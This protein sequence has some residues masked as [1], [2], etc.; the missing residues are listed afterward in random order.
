MGFSNLKEHVEYRHFLQ[1]GRI[2]FAVG[3]VHEIGRRHVVTTEGEELEADEIILCTG[4]KVSFPFL[5][6]DLSD[7]L[8][9]SNAEGKVHLNAYRLA[10]HPC[11][12]TLCALGYLLT[13]GNE[14]C[15]GEMQARWALAHWVGHHPLP[16]KEQIESDLARRKNRGK[17][18]QFVPY[19]SYMDTL[20]SAC[21]VVPDVS[22]KGFLANPW[23]S[24]KLWSSP[25]VPAQFRISGSHAWPK[26]V[27]FVKSQPFVA[28]R[29]AEL[30]WARPDSS[31]AKPA[32]HPALASRL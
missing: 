15:V 26:A 21:S 25:L 5:S 24:W 18:P 8:L 6:Q 3:G 17:Y 22:W 7:S 30:L 2:R 14:S 23:L 28:L 11:E 1:D 20:A 27:D 32:A 31:T 12:P 10:M 4:Y 16:S 9:V 13:F 29:W 19:V